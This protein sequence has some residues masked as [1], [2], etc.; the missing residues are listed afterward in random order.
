MMSSTAAWTAA[1]RSRMPADHDRP[2]A[3]YL[4]VLLRVRASYCSAYW[5]VL[6]W[7]V[8]LLFGALFMMLGVAPDAAQHNIGKWAALL[9]DQ[10]IGWAHWLGGALS[11]VQASELDLSWRG[12]FFLMGVLLL[13]T[14]NIRP[15]AH[16]ITWARQLVQE[17]RWSAWSRRM[18]AVDPEV[19]TPQHQFEIRDR[20]VLLSL[21]SPPL[22]ISASKI[23]IPECQVIAPK[24]QQY[25]STR[26]QHAYGVSA[27]SLTLT[28]SYPSDFDAP[29]L[30]LGTYTVLWRIEVEAPGL[31]LTAK[32]TDQFTVEAS[33]V[34]GQET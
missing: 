22:G 6:G 2:T 5:G 12:V 3:I 23:R 30:E 11:Q 4:P 21:S 32:R 13:V 14:T 7:V 10:P 16:A 26:C 34:T 9:Q 27:T 20:A 25:T 18:P 24:G 33:L 31:I 8:A 28:Y 29:P 1:R 15:L 17:R 19:F